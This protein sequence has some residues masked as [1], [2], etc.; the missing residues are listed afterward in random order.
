M[1]GGRY[2]LN[3]HE[4][5]ASPTGNRILITTKALKIRAIRSG[6]HIGDTYSVRGLTPSAML[7]TVSRLVGIW[8][9]CDS[10][11]CKERG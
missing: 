3:R 2:R 6:M 8:C 4:T 5:A 10:P 7:Q 11:I 9:M 1:E